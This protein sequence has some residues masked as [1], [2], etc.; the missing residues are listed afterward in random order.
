MSE[1]YRTTYQTGGGAS[2][3]RQG[4]VVGCQIKTGRRH[5]YEANQPIMSG[6]ELH[7]DRRTIPSGFDFQAIRSFR[8]NRRAM[9][10]S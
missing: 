1:T 2:P 8:T 9:P 3:E 10:H 4:I 5:G 6:V 7:G